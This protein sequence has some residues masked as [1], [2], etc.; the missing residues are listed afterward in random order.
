MDL[1]SI[2][3]KICDRIYPMKVRPQDEAYVRKAGVLLEERINQYRSISHI[4]DHQ[5][6]LAMVSFD[7]LVES[8]KAKS[9]YTEKLRAFTSQIQQWKEA[10]DQALEDHA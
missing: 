3:I 2:R 4:Q 10:I 8:L 1:L 5:D 6:L 7:F 9:N